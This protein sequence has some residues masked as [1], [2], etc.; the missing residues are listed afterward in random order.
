MEAFERMSV[1]RLMAAAVALAT[2]AAPRAARAHVSESGFVLLLPTEVYTAAGAATVALTVVALALTPS[3]VSAALSTPL[4]LGDAAP[5]CDSGATA[6]EIGLSLLSFVAM[7][8]LIVIG[9]TGA[10]DP[11]SNPL[12]L[13]VWT[14]FW[15]GLLSLQ[16][17]LGDLWRGLNPWTGL[18]ALLAGR[19]AT[20]PLRL[21]AWL[22]AWPGVLGLMIVAGFAFAHPA[23]DDPARLAVFVASY[24]VATFGL[25]LLFGPEAWLTRGECLSMLARLFAGLAPARLRGGRL[26][27]GTP[28]WRLAQAPPSI[29]AGV[30][31]LVALGVGSFDGLN[32]TFWWLALIGVNPLEFPGRSAIVG[33]TLLGL[34]LVNLALIAVFAATVLAGLLIIG[35]GAKGFSTA[36]ARLAPTVAPIALA[37]H[38][39]HYLV[40][41]MINGQYAL[42][43]ASDPL[44]VGADYLGLGVYYVTNGFLNSLDT[45]EAIFQTQAGA[46]VI[47]HVASIL[48][49]HSVAVRLFGEGRR[50]ALSQI[51]L[52]TFMVGYTF[53]G[54]W[55]LAAPKGA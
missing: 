51:P 33:E 55:L 8:A 19:D 27:I 28:G 10:R 25:I 21:P 22:G 4:R 26:E 36:F 34:V 13:S 41:A 42:A 38:I 30:F 1:P 50:A 15:V 46:V 9:L 49:A 31:A 11:L 52:A 2:A 47:G 53:I 37:Y 48:L 18:Y 7:V 39:A 44:G 29:S 40:T 6:L 20:P 54:L 45:V 14:I 3:R 5:R 16:G 17:A 43:A 12:P 23:P 32:E 35:D 24:W